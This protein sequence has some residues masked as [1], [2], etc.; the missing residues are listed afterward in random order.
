MISPAQFKPTRLNAGR[1]LGA[2][3]LLGAIAMMASACAVQKSNT[4]PVEIFSEM[5]Y[6]QAVRTQEPPRL[7]PPAESVV[8]GNT[9]APDVVL[10]VPEKK[11]RAYDPAVAAELFRINCSACHGVNGT[12]DGRATPHLKSNA[13]FYATR[14]GTPY[15]SLPPNLQESRAQRDEQTLYTIISNGLT[16]MPKFGKLMSEED[17]WDIVAFIK[18]EQTGLGT[19][20]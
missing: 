1:R 7:Q 8:Y 16:V 19:A 9:G 2:I 18:D 14:N 15:Q 10:N 11:Q 20:Q 17:I 13:S 5:H 3:A 6:S 4:Y 12:G